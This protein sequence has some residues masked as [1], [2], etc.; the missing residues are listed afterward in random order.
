M[1]LAFAF[2]YFLTCSLLILS[3]MRKNTKT[4]LLMSSLA[5]CTYFQL[6][7]L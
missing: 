5:L 2:M 7:T 1:E 3:F 6:V 4:A